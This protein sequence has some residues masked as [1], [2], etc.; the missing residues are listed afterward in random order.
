MDATTTQTIGA[1]DM[2][3]FQGLIT[4]FTM[5]V[6]AGIFWWAYRGANRERFDE[7]ALL[8][9]GEDD[10]LPGAVPTEEKKS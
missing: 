10:G 6:Y 4:A 3:V 7:D 2:G 9:F 8:P 1:L 5:V